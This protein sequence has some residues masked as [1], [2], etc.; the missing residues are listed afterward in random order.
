[1]ASVSDNAPGDIRKYQQTG[2]AWQSQ[3]N[4]INILYVTN[5]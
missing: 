1:M 2:V 5:T 4:V 3:F